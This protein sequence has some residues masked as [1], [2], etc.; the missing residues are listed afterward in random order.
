K[1]A[2][3]VVADDALGSETI[4]L[5]GA[6]ASSFEVDG[7][8]LYLKSGVSLDYETKASY[9]VTVNVA[10]ATLTGST[11]VTVNFALSVTDVN[12]TPFITVGLGDSAGATLTETN[13]SISASGTLTVTDPDPSN[14]VAISVNSVA[15]T[16]GNFNAANVPLTNSELA[17]MFTV[18]SQI[19]GPS[20]GSSSSNGVSFLDNQQGGLYVNTTPPGVT[21]LVSQWKFYKPTPPA[22]DARYLNSWVTPVILEKVGSNYVMRGVGRSRLTTTPGTYTFDF[23]LVTGSAQLANANYTY[24]HIDRNVNNPNA[25]FVSSV[26]NI[27]WSTPA[28]ATWGYLQAGLSSTNIGT[29]YTQIS[30]AGRFYASEL[31][32]N[33]ISS[34]PAD[35]PAGTSFS[36]DFNSGSTGNAAFNFLGANHTLELTYT[37]RST[38]SHNPSASQDFQVALLV[39]GTNDLAVLDLDSSSTNRDQIFTSKLNPISFTAAG[40]NL[41][42]VD[43][44]TFDNIQISF[45]KA[46]FQD[47]ANERLLVAGATNGEIAT[48]LGGIGNSVGS[49]SLSSVTFDYAVAVTNGLA[50][51]TITGQGGSE[52]TLQQ[53]EQVLDALQYNHL[54]NFRTSMPS[55]VFDVKA[56]D[57][58]GLASNV[59]VLTISVTPTVPVIL[60]GS[61]DTGRIT[62]DRVTNDT[63]L[64]LSGLGGVGDTVTIFSGSTQ[65]GSG[66]VGANGTF[67]ITTSAL[68]NGIHNLYAVASNSAGLSSSNS[69]SVSWEISN[70]QIAQPVLVS[71]NGLPQVTGTG[72]VGTVVSVVIGTATYNVPVDSNGNWTVNLSTAVPVS[73]VAPVIVAGS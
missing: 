8:A 16:G 23:E 25:N 11:P 62:T 18:Q 58:S 45:A 37:I 52:L 6:D 65:V 27:G 13:G 32:L 34:L 53:A 22:N 54:G 41:S 15:I 69:T 31:I 30:N 42:D 56:T 3:I 66:V 59:E 35:P 4:T 68:S 20:I 46:L 36:W 57:G 19:P 47:G 60:G 48:N 50:T 5:T 2:D 39:T 33:G 72:T 40:T 55:R 29:T 10:D 43:N 61:D 71:N 49:F 9:A 73:G 64:T 7:L 21:G 28:G 14:T 38:D 44:Q 17:A 24:G 1:V 12:E 67:A 51:I 26:G 63:T 70:L